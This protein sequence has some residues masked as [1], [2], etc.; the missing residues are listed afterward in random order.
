MQNILLLQVWET[1]EVFQ[2]MLMLLRKQIK[3]KLLQSGT[4]L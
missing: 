4:T 3:K 2:R 1:I